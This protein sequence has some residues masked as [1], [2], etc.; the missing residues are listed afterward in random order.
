MMPTLFF[1]LTFSCCRSGSS[2]QITLPYILSLAGFMP[3]ALPDAALRIFRVWDQHGECT[4]LRNPPVA[5]VG[6]LTGS[7]TQAMVVKTLH[8][9]HKSTTEPKASMVTLEYLTAILRGYIKNP[10][11][12]FIF[13]KRFQLH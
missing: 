6:F 11:K 13:Q 4:D 7:Q 5:E 12:R 3:Y 9:S 10:S 8:A 1:I 2:Q